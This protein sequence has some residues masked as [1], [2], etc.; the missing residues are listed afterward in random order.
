MIKTAYEYLFVI[1]AGKIAMVRKD[2]TGYSAIP[3]S[4]DVDLFSS[5]DDPTAYWNQWSELT[6][7]SIR[8]SEVDFA[9]LADK[10]DCRFAAADA[11]KSD[12]FRCAA[13]TV[14]SRQNVCAALK[15][16]MRASSFAKSV[17][18]LEKG[19]PLLETKIDDSDERLVLHLSRFGVVKD[20]PEE[21]KV[22]QEV[23]AQCDA[24]VKA[25]VAVKGDFKDVSQQEK[26]Q[27]PAP[28]STGII[29]DSYNDPA[30]LKLSVGDELK[31]SIV[32]IFNAVKR[33]YVK[34][35][36]LKGEVCFKSANAKEFAV[37]DKIKL[38]VTK[39]DAESKKVLFS[40][41]YV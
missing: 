23:G 39:V 1:V 27:K 25:P 32:K 21:S 40:V 3:V 5:F 9:F 15:S 4:D 36:G 29:G 35:E 31:G 10:K 8:H 41:M 33:N 16:V 22:E 17:S 37:G 26:H 14:W 7:F 2:E 13:Q 18:V 20:E 30:A 28:K 38:M 6:N 11:K 24:Q 34:V 19:K 12:Q